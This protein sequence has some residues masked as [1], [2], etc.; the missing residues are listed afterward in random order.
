[1]D[2]KLAALSEEH[3]KEKKQ[4]ETKIKELEKNLM[5]I[6]VLLQFVFM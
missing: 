2:T 4:F 5:S 1:M 3:A 6:E